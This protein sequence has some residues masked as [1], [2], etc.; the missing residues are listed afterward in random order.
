MV[1]GPGGAGSRAL[2]SRDLA[3]YYRQRHRPADERGSVVAN[4]LIA[5]YR[6]LGVATLEAR[7][8]ER[9][10]ATHIASVA[11][12]KAKHERLALYLRS[13]VNRNLPKNCPH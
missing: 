8:P 7:T 1:P 3:R 4:A 13:T 5:K 2:G 10:A 12:S 11:A 6:A 9:A